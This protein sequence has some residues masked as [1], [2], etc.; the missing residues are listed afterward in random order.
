MSEMTLRDQFAMAVLTGVI[1]S[2]GIGFPAEQPAT[3]E[4]A[5]RMADLIL[6]A[7]DKARSTKDNE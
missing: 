3:I 4:Q 2:R 5:Y 7:R 6:K 1:A